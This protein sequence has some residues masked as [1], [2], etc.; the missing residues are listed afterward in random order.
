MLLSTAAEGLSAA[1]I[2]YERHG[3]ADIA[4]VVHH[5]GKVIAGALF[6]C[7][8]GSRI[9]GH[10]LAEQVV[11]AGA[12]ALLVE[13]RLPVSVPQVV[14]PSV[15]AAMGP[16]AACFFDDPSR[17]MTVVGITGTN[18]KTTTVS[19]L[20][21]IFEAADLRC[22]VIGTLT[23]MPGGPPTT[24]DAPELQ[25]QL[26][27]WRDDGVDAVAMEVSSHALAMG[28]VDGTWFAAT[29]FTMLGHDHLDLHVDIDHYF[30]AKARLFEP[31]RT[32]R[33]V[34]RSDDAWGARLIDAARVETRG[35][36]LADAS[37]LSPRP[38]GVSFVWREQRIELPMTGRHNVANA[39]CAATIAEW[40]GI[41][42]ATITTGLAGVGSVRGRFELVDAGQDF[43]V[44]VDYAHTPDALEIVL[45]AARE[46]ADTADGRV[47]VVFGCGGDKDRE[48]RPAM[49][50]IA[51]AAADVVIVTSD[52]PR[53]EDPDAI[54]AEILDG[55]PPDDR[56]A[57]EAAGAL[58]VRADRREAIHH[59]ARAA[60]KH[61]VVVIAGKGHETTQTF[62]DETVP[63]DDRMVAREAARAVRGS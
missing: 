34:V 25:A 48:K 39:L 41:D 22:E 26:A 56:T 5:A 29:G 38:G 47:L 33:A 27:T 60:R 35:F 14:V 30:A 16:L 3:D 55:I 9:D 24:P 53:S 6:C 32:S 61:D 15:R 17:A 59:A 20:R 46:L 44:A 10:D 19:L 1:G 40:L 51:A 12:S 37:D 45:E 63:F 50:R 36:S 11:A 18:G 52:N 7:V 58:L 31:E 42:V 23:S 21:A 4:G 2:A 13:R 28:R 49:G 54:I 43:T 62:A 8:P 57:S